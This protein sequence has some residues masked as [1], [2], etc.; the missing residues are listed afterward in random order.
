MSY[1]S[2]ILK[3]RRLERNLTLRE[4]ARQTGYDVGN[5]SKIER[6]ILNPP[7]MIAVKGWA[8]A[9]SLEPGTEEYEEF[10]TEA[11][12]AKDE[13][14]PNVNKDLRE[15]LPVLLRSEQSK[16]LSAEEFECLVKTLK[17]SLM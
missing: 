6:G 11:A 15:A 1:F 9:L 3:K 12:L 10:V 17:K 16:K 5:L 13:I 8:K 7:A 4:F 14:P 2:H